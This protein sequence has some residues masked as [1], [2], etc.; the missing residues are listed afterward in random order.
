MLALV[1]IF[2]VILLKTSHYLLSQILQTKWPVIHDE[3]G[4]AVCK[5]IVKNRNSVFNSR[6]IA[7]S[8]NF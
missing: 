3:V 2:H 4:Y 6:C 8:C 7:F 5:S 1:G